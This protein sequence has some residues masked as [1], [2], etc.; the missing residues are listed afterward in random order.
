METSRQLLLSMLLV[1]PSGDSLEWIQANSGLPAEDFEGAFAQLLDFSLVETNR[2]QVSN[3]YH[4]HRITQ[5]FLKTNI[6]Q[7][8]DL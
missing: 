3:G 1:S 4:L 2:T 5:A 6:L 8:W 7:E